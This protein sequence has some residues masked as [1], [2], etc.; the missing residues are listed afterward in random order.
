MVRF[1]RRSSQSQQGL[2]IGVGSMKYTII[3]LCALASFACTAQPNGRG[4]SCTP[5]NSSLKTFLQNRF[6]ENHALVLK[7][8]KSH[9]FYNIPTKY[10][11]ATVQLNSGTASQVIVFLT[12]S[13]W[14]GSGGC[15]LL[16]L[17]SEGK[18]YKVVAKIS[19]VLLPVEVLQSVTNEWHDIAVHV[20]GYAGKPEYTTILKFNGTTYPSNPSMTP[21]HLPP[22]AKLKGSVLPLTREACSLYNS[23]A[24]TPPAGR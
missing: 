14:C 12:G 13:E 9:N 15:T 5:T 18:S 7:L 4:G 3:A 19:I 24:P 11:S 21:V 10:S 20:R 2:A 1:S 17:S 16:I 23:G 8:S 6:M 22:N